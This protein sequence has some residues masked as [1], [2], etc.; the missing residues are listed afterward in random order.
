MIINSNFVNIPNMLANL[1]RENHKELHKIAQRIT[2]RKNINLA[3]ELINETYIELVRKEKI[4]PKNQLE[5]IKWFSKAMK[6]IYI[7]RDSG[8]NKAIRIQAAENFEL[9]LIDNEA[10]KDIDFSVE[11]TNEATKELMQISS[12]M[13]KD[14]ALRYIQVLEF[15]SRLPLH[16]RYLFE[17]YFERGLSCR[18]ISEL[19]KQISGENIDYQVINIMV[20]S[21]KNKIKNIKW[22]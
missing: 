10:L 22:Q 3:N 15:K 6:N 18:K 12:G 19:E 1:Y 5:F 16:E 14:R 4:A 2:R 13:A 20:N 9:E 8:F 11:K 7:W 21:I 17:I